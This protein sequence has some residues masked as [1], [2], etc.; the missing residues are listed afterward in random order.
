MLTLLISNRF[1]QHNRRIRQLLS[2]NRYDKTHLHSERKAIS[3]STFVARRA[4]IQHASK[5]TNSNN[6]GAAM[7]VVGSVAVTPNNNPV[8]TRVK[9][10]AANQ[11]MPMPHIAKRIP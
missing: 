2:S 10:K 1:L 5:A 7:N 9:P 6:N 11:P 8:N 4:G 3:G